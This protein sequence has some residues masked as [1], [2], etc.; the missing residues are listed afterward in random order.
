MKRKRSK[1]I[2]FFFLLPLLFGSF[3][4]LCVPLFLIIK[5]SFWQEGIEFIGIEE[6]KKLFLSASFRIA[7]KNTVLFL[8]AAIPLLFLFSLSTALS[9]QY[10]HKKHCHLI[11]ILFLFHLL[12][13]LIPS[14]VITVVFRIFFGTYGI[15]NGLLIQYGKE[16]IDFFYSEYDRLFLLGIYL[17][18]N[19][20]YCMILLYGGIHNVPEETIES[21]KLDGAN[22]ITLLVQILL[23]QIRTFLT[24]VGALGVIGIFKIFREAY[25]LFGKYP[26]S[27]V[28]LLQNFIH[29]KLYA[30]DY[31]SLSTV[32]CLLLFFFSIWIAILFLPKQ[33]KSKNFLN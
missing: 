4:F 8:L 13:M 26:H 19:Y 33:K 18:K 1:A 25:F 7:V 3:L 27:S 5:E 30:M 32:S 17:W 21:A 23:P 6:Y 20:G 29:N 15:V 16:R 11:P 2:T 22:V 9:M 10:L 12:P 28:Y 14:A 24:F 31:N